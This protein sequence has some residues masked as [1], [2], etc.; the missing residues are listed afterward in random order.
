MKITIKFLEV[1]EADTIFRERVLEFNLNGNTVK[2]LI[3]EII[4]TY[5]KK[6]KELFFDKGEYRSNLQ[7]I[8]NWMRYVTPDMMDK[9]LLNENDT[10]IFA[11]LTDGG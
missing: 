10:V 11:P 1:F 6:A 9:F 8:I 7:I 5:G 2:D 4:E 3:N